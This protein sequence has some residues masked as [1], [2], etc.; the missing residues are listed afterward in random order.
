MG[1]LPRGSSRCYEER[2]ILEEI[3]IGS[4]PELPPD[5]TISHPNHRHKHEGK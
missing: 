1:M 4:A 2:L 3:E 5:A